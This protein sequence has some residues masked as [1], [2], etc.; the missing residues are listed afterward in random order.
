[1]GVA[2]IVL[3]S[4]RLDNLGLSAKAND[5]H[6]EHWARYIAACQSSNTVSMRF[7]LATALRIRVNI[8]CAPGGA[9]HKF[10][11]IDITTSIAVGP[12]MWTITPSTSQPT[13]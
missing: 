13:N 3:P 6:F 2:E 8:C 7:R 11:S 12:A 4:C 5:P 9:A 1:M 10:D